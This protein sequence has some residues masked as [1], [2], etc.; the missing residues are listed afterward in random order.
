MLSQEARYVIRL[1]YDVKADI[2]SN[3]RRVR[4]VLDGAVSHSRELDRIISELE[5]SY[6]G[7]MN[8]AIETVDSNISAANN[9]SLE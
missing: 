3:R 5:S 1:S 7:V 9:S 2:D 8:T 4:S 6:E